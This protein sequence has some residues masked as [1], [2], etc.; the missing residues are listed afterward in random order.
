M[1]KILSQHRLITVTF[2]NNIKCLKMWKIMLIMK[3]HGQMIMSIFNKQNNFK[4]KEYRNLL[5]FQ[6]LMVIIWKC[7]R[8]FLKILILILK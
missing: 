1:K 6:I 7:M 5:K 8:I 3:H 2:L 4:E